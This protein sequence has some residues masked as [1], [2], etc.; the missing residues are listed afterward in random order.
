MFYEDR[1]EGRP[2]LRAVL[3]I[4]VHGDTHDDK[5][6]AITAI[7]AWLDVDLAERNG[8]WFAQREWTD[9]GGSLIILE[10]HYTPDHDKAYAL[11]QQAV[12]AAP[13]GT[14]AR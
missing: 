1:P 4:K 9:P 6:H 11:R 10:A 14:D 8:T 2:D 12:H 5:M 13:A 3:N 7:A